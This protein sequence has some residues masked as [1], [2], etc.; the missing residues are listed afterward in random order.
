MKTR[1]VSGLL[2]L[3]LLVLIAIGGEVINLMC[4]LIA[5][6]GVREFYNAFKHKDVKPSMTIA[7]VCVFL[8]FI[9]P[10]H[11][12]AYTQR[13]GDSFAFIVMW[14]M[15]VMILSMLYMF[16]IKERKLEDGIVTA[17]GL[18]YVAF[19]AYHVVLLDTLSRQIFH[20]DLFSFH[21]AGH[22]YSIVGP[23]SIV[24]L[25]IFCAFGTDV[26]AYFTGYLFGKHKLCK[27]ISPKK[28][29]EGAVG[30][31]IGATVLCSAYAYIFMREYIVYVVIMAVAGSIF[32][33]LGDL[34]ASIFKRKLEIKDYGDLIP[35]HGGVLD[36]FDS[37]LFAAPFMYYLA[38]ILW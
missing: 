9:V 37:V 11:I 28:T 30:G 26:F 17:F 14:V 36:R 10:G 6:I 31:V 3:P 12:A 29:V 4:F 2:M 33:Q 35:G 24:W 21:I 20:S 32:S 16:N 1:V 19:F 27:T 7:S 38:Y 13:A 22:A 18:I 34:S 15:L 8:L 23:Y 25:V 5:L